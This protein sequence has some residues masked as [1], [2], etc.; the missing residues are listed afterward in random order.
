MRRL[1]SLRRPV[2][3]AA[4]REVH[5]AEQAA[6]EGQGDGVADVAALAVEFVVFIPQYAF[7]R[8][9]MGVGAREPG[10]FV[11]AVEIHHQAVAR[12]GLE[13]LHD[14]L[15]G[16]LRVAVE[17]VHLDAD[18]AQAGEVGERAFHA[19][20]FYVDGVRPNPEAHAALA[21]VGDE[22]GGIDVRLGPG[23]VAGRVV[24]RRV[25][26]L[27]PQG[28]VLI[29]E[30]VHEL[31]GPAHLGGEVDI[32][33]VR[34][35]VAARIHGGEFRERGVFAGPPGVPRAH[36]R[37]HPREIGDAAGRGEA[38]DEVR[39]NEIGGVARDQ[40][41][42]PGA[43]HRSVADDRAAAVVAHGEVGAHGGFARAADQ[44]ACP[45]EQVGLGDG[46]VGGGRLDEQRRHAAV[47]GA[48][49]AER[50]D[51]AQLRLGIGRLGGRGFAAGP[52]TV[53]SGEPKLRQL[54]GER[55]LLG[56]E[57]GW[58]FVAE[59]KAVVI[60]AD[61]EPEGAARGGFAQ[62]QAQLAPVVRHVAARAVGVF[63]RAVVARVPGAGDAGGGAEHEAVG[64]LEPELRV[65]EEGA[66][67]QLDAVAQAG[68][69][70]DHER[71]TPVG[72]DHPV[73]GCGHTE[74]CGERE[75][76]E[77]GL[78]LLGCGERTAGASFKRA[79][80]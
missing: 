76:R 80:R 7:L 31:V 37:A 46:D 29:P 43:A 44:H 17:E 73:L 26:P 35:G 75:A 22:A 30:P 65:G 5:R 49:L 4:G 63:P 59:G 68:L 8:E 9:K 32:L 71:E 67:V 19:E 16:F 50:G 34:T 15:H 54:P 11:D 61:D 74:G 70:G 77:R 66:A 20:G 27:V 25:Q 45:V 48:A 55:E 64:K 53:V 38:G 23:E 79:R 72:R 10:G 56:T 40:Q 21:G 28:Q 1:K 3:E 24:G 60:H 42:A 2:D 18:E 58:Q 78:H 33:A 36:A 57:L 41:R 39:G 62:G 51:G 12:G 6:G 69:V 14:P 13:Q 52:A 47:G